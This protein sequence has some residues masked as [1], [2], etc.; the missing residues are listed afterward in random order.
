MESSDDPLFLQANG[1]KSTYRRPPSLEKRASNPFDI[2][3]GDNRP[4]EEESSELSELSNLSS[5]PTLLKGRDQPPVDAEERITRHG[6]VF[7]QSRHIELREQGKKDAQVHWVVLGDAEDLEGDE[8]TEEDHAFEQPESHKDGNVPFLPGEE[9]GVDQQDIT[10]PYVVEDEMMVIDG[11]TFYEGPIAEEGPMEQAL[12]Y[13]ADLEG[14]QEVQE[15][16]GVPMGDPELQWVFSE[17]D[18]VPHT[19]DDEIAKELKNPEEQVEIEE[20]IEDLLQKMPGLREDYELIDRLGTGTFSS[21]YKAT[22]RRYSEWDN[23]LWQVE[24]PQ[25]TSMLYPFTRSG[26]DKAPED[27]IL[28]KAKR[29]AYV[30]IKR[31]MV[32]SSPKRIVNEILI[33]ESCRGCR[34]VAQI[35]TVYRV[36]DQIVIVMPYQRSTDLR[37]KYIF[38]A[39]LR[40]L[41]LYF[42]DLV[43]DLTPKGIRQYFRCMFRA[44][45]DIHARGIIH[46]D[47]KPGNFLFDPLTWTGTMVDF[48]LAEVWIGLILL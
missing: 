25:S 47:L 19:S 2:S 3:A 18:F 12:E 37:V 7:V 21:V 41:T 20:E 9:E 46:R 48:G 43:K 34:N 24:H 15:V 5:D 23:R 1:N 17:G 42:Q 8:R 45:R 6:K 35:I 11:D 26:R 30:A 39:Y 27:S 28:S 4:L 13:D 32:T 10:L 33:M 16:D 40:L 38:S 44:L 36:E 14:D 29:P 22:D 31:I